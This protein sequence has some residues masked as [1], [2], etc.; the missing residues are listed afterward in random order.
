MLEDTKFY[1][2][3]EIAEMFGVSYQMVYRMVRTGELTALKFGKNYRVAET[4]LK[5]YLQKQREGV[6]DA[7]LAQTC[8]RCGKSFYSSQSIVG[9][10]EVCG[11]PLCINCVKLEHA[12]KCAEHERKENEKDID[13]QP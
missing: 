5:A 13:I 6:K 2:L 11:A 9:E 10:C 8:A 12:T 4:D 7:I 1:T 3:E